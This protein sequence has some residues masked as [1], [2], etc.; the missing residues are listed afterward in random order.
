MDLLVAKL[1]EDYELVIQYND[2]MKNSLVG[3]GEAVDNFPKTTKIIGPTETALYNL[4]N[5]GG[6][7]S[8]ALPQWRATAES[9]KKSK[10]TIAWPASIKTWY[11]MDQAY[12]VSISC[13]PSSGASRLS[14]ES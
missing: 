2:D 4:W 11:G 8:G 14:G 7:K 13:H 10:K 5:G 3:V 6:V 1:E 12:V 9:F